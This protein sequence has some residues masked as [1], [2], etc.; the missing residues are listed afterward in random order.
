MIPFLSFSQGTLSVSKHRAQSEALIL[1]ESFSIKNTG[2]QLQQPSLHFSLEML[3]WHCHWQQV[4]LAHL[5][6]QDWSVFVLFFLAILLTC[7]HLSTSFFLLSLS[8]LPC[9]SLLFLTST[10]DVSSC[11][12]V[13]GSKNRNRAVHGDVVVVELLPRSEWKGKVTALTE[14]QGEEK[15]RE[16]N[17]SKPLPTGQ[18]STLTELIDST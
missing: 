16:D 2:E 1:T 12:L 4:D 17:E 11:V 6:S 9:F 14:G 7:S 8:S 18:T 15:N 10:S 13:C 5:G 3:L